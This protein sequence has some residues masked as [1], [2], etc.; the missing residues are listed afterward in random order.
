VWFPTHVVAPTLLLLSVGSHTP[1]RFR[2]IVGLQVRKYRILK[3]WTQR[4]LA[5][6]CQVSGWNLTRDIVAGIEN[7]TRWIGDFELVM[8]SRVLEVPIADLLP[9]R[10][11]WKELDSALR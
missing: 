3:G 9:D 7:R 10:V 1:P 4:A 6:R 11:N 5:H 2:N 8:L